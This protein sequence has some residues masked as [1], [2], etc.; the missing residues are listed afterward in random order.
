M[1]SF[2]SETLGR[3]DRSA[4]RSGNDRIDT[5][6]RELVTQDV[7]RK[8]A[9]GYVLVERASAKV[10]GFYTLSAHAIPLSEIADDVARKLPRYPSVPAV[11]I[12]W[13]G[14]AIDFRGQGIGNL[15]LADAIDR[16][17]HS[18]VGAHAIC[19]DAIDEAAAAS[20]RAHGF[21]PFVSR[22]QGLYLPVKTAA[23]LFPL[24][25]RGKALD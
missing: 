16:L 18:P 7:K 2:F 17:V 14:R 13:L 4:F 3:H 8:Y 6:F 23:A 11:L 19:A 15:L 21:R 12:G 22:P 25:R 10:A 9:A 1:T 5:Y 20:Y 24:V